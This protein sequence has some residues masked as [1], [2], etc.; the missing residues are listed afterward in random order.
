MP[1]PSPARPLTAREAAELAA[2]VDAER[3]L[4]RPRSRL[5]LKV[6][7][8][9]RPDN[10]AG[11]RAQLTK[12]QWVAAWSAASLRPLRSRDDQAFGPE[13]DSD[14]GSAVR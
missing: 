1:R 14:V 11:R 7:P 6:K 4:R 12:K 13:A 2:T 5:S 9:R 3:R 10:S 8:E